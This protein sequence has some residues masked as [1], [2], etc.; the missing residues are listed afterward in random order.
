MTPE[1]LVHK[2]RED[3]RLTPEQLEACK[4]PYDT[5]IDTWSLPINA[6]AEVCESPVLLE[7][8]RDM[9]KD[10]WVDVHVFCQFR[11]CQ[12]KG[13]IVDKNGYIVAETPGYKTRKGLRKHLSDAPWFRLPQE[14][15]FRE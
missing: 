4:R 12:W 2:W 15:M 11:E 6:D 10:I 9:S 1:E 13:R 14:V 7:Y 3:R 8:R 5:D